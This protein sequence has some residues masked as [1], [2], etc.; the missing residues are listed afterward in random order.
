MM[1]NLLLAFFLTVVLNLFLLQ[2]VY[3]V[4]SDQ[5]SR[6]ASYPIALLALATIG[7]SLYLF[8]VIFQPEKF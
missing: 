7:V 2:T 1:K 5:I 4:T 6:A 8:V 3:A